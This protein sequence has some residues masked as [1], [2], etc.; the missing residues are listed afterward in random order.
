MA[1]V[2]VG[3]VVL[4]L[5]SVGT[6]KTIV[7]Q[8]VFVVGVPSCGLTVHPRGYGFGVQCLGPHPEIIDT[9]IV[10]VVSI[11]RGAQVHLD[12][13]LDGVV[14]VGPRMKEGTVEVHLHD[15]RIGVLHECPVVPT[16]FIIFGLSLLIDAVIAA[17]L[18][19]VPINAAIAPRQV[20]IDHTLSGSVDAFKQGAVLRLDVGI[21]VYPA[22]DGDF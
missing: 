21:T 6:I 1:G 17:I 4:F 18:T 5:C 2:P 22:F 9:A 13:A 12:D 7:D 11:A 20:H 19:A 14:L 8:Q 3:A 15:A 16:P 10:A